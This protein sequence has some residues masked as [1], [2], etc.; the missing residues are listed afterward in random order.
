MVEVAVFNFPVQANWFFHKFNVK[1]NAGKMTGIKIFVILFVICWLKF[2]QWIPSFA[3]LLIC[4]FAHLL[5]C[6]FA[7]LLICSFAHL[8][9]CFRENSLSSAKSYLLNNKAQ[10]FTQRKFAWRTVPFFI[11]IINMAENKK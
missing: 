11:W 1:N 9:I 10:F 6:S 8:L 3:H 2:Y 5:I 7:H 4:S